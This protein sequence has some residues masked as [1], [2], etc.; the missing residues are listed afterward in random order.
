MP[1][2]QKGYD[3]VGYKSQGRDKN[4]QSDQRFM[5]T[6]RPVCDNEKGYHSDHT[7][8]RPICDRDQMRNRGTVGYHTVNQG[9]I[10]PEAQTRRTS[11]DLNGDPGVMK[12]IGRLTVPRTNTPSDTDDLVIATCTP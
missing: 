1:R 9:T 4:G 10:K 7:Y 2:A 6:F 5:R 8:E 12:S 3:T 11:T